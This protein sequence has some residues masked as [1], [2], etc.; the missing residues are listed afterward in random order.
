MSQNKPL[1]KMIESVKTE[2]GVRHVL[3]NHDTLGR[4]CVSQATPRVS[5]GCLPKPTWE[6]GTVVR[7][8]HGECLSDLLREDDRGHRRLDWILWSQNP[9]P[10][11]AVAIAKELGLA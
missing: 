2:G 1:L 7:V 3:V 5:I 9:L 10:I 4:M 11:T 6:S 8:G